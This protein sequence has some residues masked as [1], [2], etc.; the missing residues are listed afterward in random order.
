MSGAAR[1]S[2]AAVLEHALEHVGRAVERGQIL[3]REIAHAAR[4]IGVLARAQAEQQIAARARDADQGYAPI[5]GVA[6]AID[7]TGR[8]EARDH[9][10]RRRALDALDL[11][12]SLGVS[13]P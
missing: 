4:E 11:A 3:S 7:K 12:S 5:G 2:L 8:L 1:R 13:G 6:G 9:P 10:G